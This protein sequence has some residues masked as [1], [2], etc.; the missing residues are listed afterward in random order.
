MP[1]EFIARGRTAEVFAWDTDK[2]VKLYRPGFSA[3]DAQYEAKVAAA[4]QEAGVACPRFY[5][6]VEFEGR[7]GLVY[8]RI[9]GV[10]M[11]KMALKAPWR[12]P[13]LARRMAA[14]HWQMH[15]PKIEAPLPGQRARIS[16]RIERVAILPAALKSRLLDEYQKI[17]D[18][19]RL[20]HGDF[21]PENILSTA[22]KDLTIDWV[23][24]T[25]GH[26]MGDV[27]RTSILLLGM[28]ATTNPLTRL[29][30]DWFHHH[31]L[32][33]YFA[34]GGDQAVYRAFLPIVAAARLAEGIPELQGFLLKQ[35][36]AVY[37]A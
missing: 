25:V 16:R 13:A 22:E 32:Q 35:A 9:E 18:E 27:A 10:P 26:P 7:P 36:E 11:S 14:L 19:N 3:E 12:I 24:T 33:A 37:Q 8:E 5:E 31:Y 28:S 21:H 23:D 15:Q 34:S 1:Q 20:C 29:I 2:V 30:V 17:P 4:V 6:L